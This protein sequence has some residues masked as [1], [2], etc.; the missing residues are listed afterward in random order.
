MAEAKAPKVKINKRLMLVK[1]ILVALVAVLFAV[2]MVAVIVTAIN[3]SKVLDNQ[4]VFVRG[5]D[6]AAVPV[7]A[8][9]AQEITRMNLQ[10]IFE[11]LFGA[12]MQNG[13]NKLFGQLDRIENK[14]LSCPAY[15]TEE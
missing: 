15:V 2:T 5:N 9:E 1:H 10:I 12:D 13:N 6:G 4:K 8:T 14:E 11:T 3:V 7:T